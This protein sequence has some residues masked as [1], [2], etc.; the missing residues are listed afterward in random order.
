MNHFLEISQHWHSSLHQ[1]GEV[2]RRQGT[3]GDAARKDWGRSALNHL[4]R[5][6]H[7]QQAGYY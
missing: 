7:E 4:E 1:N 5:G 3:G 6:D 2:P